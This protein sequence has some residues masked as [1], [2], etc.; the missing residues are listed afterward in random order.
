MSESQDD[1]EA[2]HPDWVTFEPTITTT[3]TTADIFRVFTSGDTTNEVLQKT[4]QQST[5]KPLRYA[6]DSSCIQEAGTRAPVE[7]D[8]D[9]ISDSRHRHE[10]KGYIGKENAPVIQAMI[11][12]LRARPH[13]VR[14]RWVKG[15]NGHTLNEGA[16]QLANERARKTHPDEIDLTIPPQLTQTGAKL[17][18]LTQKLAYQG[19]RQREMTKYKGRTRTKDNITKAIDYAEHYHKTSPTEAMIWKS[20]RH[21]DLRREARYFLWMTTHNAYMVG[22]NWLRPGYSDNLQARHEC[23]VCGKIESMEHILTECTIPAQAEVWELTAELW[24][25]KQRPWHKPMIGGIIGCA[26]AAF[27]DEKGKILKGLTRLY[28][29]LVS[30]AAHQIW[31]LRNAQV[32]NSED[33]E[34]PSIDEIRNKWMNTINNR[35]AMDCKM[36]SKKKYGKRAIKETLVGDTW[37]GVL[38]NE[39]YLPHDWTKGR[40]EVLVGI[41]PG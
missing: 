37:S 15:H 24:R 25:K 39:K 28:R 27:K 26:N 5:D 14:L 17:A 19:I 7:R 41:D 32:I 4:R 21:K 40:V 36:T 3:G 2:N 18:T 13:T 30:E 8:L 12:L 1:E 35:L 10:D 38:K 6:T 29:I 11:A 20:I 23:T 22:S 16:Y 9:V 33:N 31:K 34:P